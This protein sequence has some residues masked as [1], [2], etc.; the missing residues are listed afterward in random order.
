[1]APLQLYHS[2]L[3]LAPTKSL[4][5]KAHTQDLDA[6]LIICRGARS[7]WASCIDAFKGHGSNVFAVAFSPSGDCFITGG[8]DC[9]LR[10]WRSA[11]RTMILSFD[12]HTSS[13][14]CVAFSP[15]GVYVASGSKYHDVLV[16]QLSTGDCVRVLRGHAARPVVSMV[17]LADEQHIL[18]CTSEGDME[19]WDLS[20][21]HCIFTLKPIENVGQWLL[22]ISPDGGVIAC[23]N[24][25]SL[26][27]HDRASATNVAL[28][29]PEQVEEATFSPDGRYVAARSSHI[30]RVWR[31]ADKSLVR[32]ID[33]L[34]D[35]LTGRL[36]FSRDGARVGC[37]ALH[38]PFYPWQGVVYLWHIASETPPRILRGHGAAVWDL[39]WSPNGLEVVSVSQDGSVRVW[40]ITQPS[41][42]AEDVASQYR[43][44]A[45]EP[46]RFVFAPDGRRFTLLHLPLLDINVLDSALPEG[47]PALIPFADMVD[48]WDGV[49][50]VTG[51]LSEITRI[52]PWAAV[53]GQQH[54]HFTDL[55]VDV[56]PRRPIAISSDGFLMAQRSSTP[57]R[58]VDIYDLRTGEGLTSLAGRDVVTSIS[59]SHDGTLIATASLDRSVKVWDSANGAMLHSYDQ[60]AGRVKA[61][62]FSSDGHLVA[63][64]SYDETVHV[65]EAATG[66]V[67][68]VFESHRTCVKEL[69]FATEN[70]RI[71]SLDNDLWFYI[72]D[73]A[74]G[75]RVYDI[76]LGNDSW[77]HSL[78]FTPDGT[79]VLIPG[80]SPPAALMV[81]LWKPHERV[82]PV[83]VVSKE[84]WL[85]EKGPG[86]TARLCWLPPEWRTVSPLEGGK[87]RAPQRAVFDISQL[88]GYV[89]M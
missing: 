36:A 84:G 76:F 35:R 41:T 13:V 81:S 10:M 52:R 12:G 83:Y 25:S 1:M 30:I 60:H 32:T 16:W 19:L 85:Y 53:S 88:P 75:T 21:G 80:E 31:F 3:P 39:S 78:H 89:C 71:L 77:I 47:T 33:V 82:W 37:G 56:M 62:V 48:V 69:A 54:I 24:D 63:S 73:I 58:V 18:S 57:N 14:S 66:R 34:D 27:L 42:D 45:T 55:Q 40:D 8:G 50:L 72:W 9:R 38:G 64:G 4:V 74:S 87:L 20:D 15:N 28:D 7:E 65:F 11:T 17:F 23:G 59:F 68:Q 22:G 6:S 51:W 43:L 2:A 61:L 70:T 67:V 26:I 79:G 29:F 44:T 46:V 5:K 49:A 86:L